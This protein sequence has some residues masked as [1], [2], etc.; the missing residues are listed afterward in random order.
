MLPPN[1]PLVSTSWATGLP[2]DLKLSSFIRR[3]PTVFHESHVLDSGGTRVPCFSL[4]CEALVLFQEELMSFSRISWM[5]GIDSANCLCSQ[6][7]RLFHYKQLTNLK[8][9]MGFT[10]RLSSFFC[11][12]SP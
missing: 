1:I 3:Y 6:E 8:W 10:I 11:F 9:D 2:H 4:T 5:F 12:R 7:I